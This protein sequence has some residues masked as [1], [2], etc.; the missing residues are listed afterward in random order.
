MT[1]IC[2]LHDTATG[3]TWIGANTGSTIADTPL[4]AYDRKWL[5]R[6]PWALGLAGDGRVSNL[7]EA[8]AER[9]FE[10]LEE[11]Y[12]L[13]QR[14]RQ[15]FDDAGIKDPEKAAVPSYGQAMIL[16]TA[17]AVYDLDGALAFSPIEDGRLWARGSGMDFALG[18]DH[19][20]ADLNLPAETR[21]R[22]AVL[23]A[24]ANDV[25]CPGELYLHKLELRGH[26]I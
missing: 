5:M 24:M 23:A 8:E 20:L 9:L 10:D 2:A 11:P 16:A 19:A 14:I 3:G 25:F 15:I 12:E 26:D 21:V 22:K 17:A 4:P 1:I 13:T 18:A 7:L 6:G